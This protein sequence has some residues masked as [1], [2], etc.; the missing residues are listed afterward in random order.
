MAIV[1]LRFSYSHSMERDLRRLLPNGSFIGVPASR[2]K[3]MRAIK[4]TGNRTTEGR[5]RLALVRQ[6]VRGWKIRPDGLPGSPDFVFPKGRLAIF[7]DGCFWHGCE[8]CN[9]ARIQTNAAFWRAKMALNRAKDQRVVRALQQAGWRVMRVWEHDLRDSLPK[10]VSR[11][12]K[13]LSSR[14]L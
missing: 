2:S 5:L 3:V 8:R 12:T 9:K 14:A 11:I 4:G 7:A 13:K 10:V 6:G 1:P